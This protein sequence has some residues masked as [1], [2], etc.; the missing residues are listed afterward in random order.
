M[1]MLLPRLILAAG[2][3]A[4][5][6]AARLERPE[7]APARSPDLPVVAANDNL[8]PAGVLRNDTLRLNLV[9]QMGRWYPEVGY[10]FALNARLLLGNVIVAIV[11]SLPF[12]L[13]GALVGDAAAALPLF[14]VAV[15]LHFAREVMKDVAD[16]PGDRGHRDTIPLRWGARAACGVA[17]AGVVTYAALATW[18]FAPSGLRALGLLP[19]VSVAAWA[20]V[21]TPARAPMLLKL[22]MLLAMAALPFL[23]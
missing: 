13:G 8:T 18:L 16:A 3:T 7:E 17:L 11:A 1:A 10:A 6:I 15:P 21:K 19:S 2:L 20:V 9:V 4:S 22:A 5:L 23:R 12:L 14:A